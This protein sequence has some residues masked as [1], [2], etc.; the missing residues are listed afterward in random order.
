MIANCPSPDALKSFSL[1]QLPEEHSD[2]LFSHLQTCESCQQ[3]IGTLET[4]GDTFVKRL[5]SASEE[6]PDEYSGENDCLTAKARAL[7]ALA[8]VEA[9][10][11]MPADFPKTIG[12]YEI[13]EPLGQG[14]MGHVFFGATH[15]ARSTSRDQVHRKSSPLGSDHAP[16]ICIRNANDWQLKP[17]QHR[18]RPR[19]AGGGRRRRVGD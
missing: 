10:E 11:A 16:E 13:V 1:G 12:E 9:G 7:A 8:T 17:P 15:Q 18:R 14:G 2:I 19:R 3:E 6:L 4:A 5:K